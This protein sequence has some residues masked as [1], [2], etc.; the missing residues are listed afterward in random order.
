[1]RKMP[2]LP[3][4]THIT[5]KRGVI[6][7]LIFWQWILQAQRGQAER[8]SGAIVLLDESHE[9]VMRWRFRRAWPT[10]YRGPTL[11]ATGNEV[12]IEEIVLAHEGLELD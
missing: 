3:K 10:A 2:G 7:D 5:L 12:A 4:Y 9:P 11:K 1:M 8:Q 6:G